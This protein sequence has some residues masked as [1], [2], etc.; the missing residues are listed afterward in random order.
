MTG[1]RWKPAQIFKR[2]YSF[3]VP[4]CSYRRI[5]CDKLGFEMPATFADPPVMR[6]EADTRDHFGKGMVTMCKSTKR[7]EGLGS[8]A[9]SWTDG[10]AFTRSFRTR[11]R[12][13]RGR[14][15]VSDCNERTSGTG[16]GFQLVCGE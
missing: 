3:V 9:Y 14:Q 7:A 10:N 2:R 6:G 16:N 1:V 12:D 15:R 5:L 11:R 13:S 4:E 8:D